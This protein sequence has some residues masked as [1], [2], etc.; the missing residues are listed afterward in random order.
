MSDICL[1]IDEDSMDK[2]LINGL[3]A[4]N[5][6][7]IT[8]IE[9]KTQSYTDEKQLSLATSLNRVLYSHNIS[10][11]CRLHT[12]FTTESKI[13]SGIA[14]LAQDYYIGEQLKAIMKFISVKTT[15]D[16][17]NQLEFLSKYLK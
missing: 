1:Y 11:F 15:D 4:R 9:T 10:D 14:L 12:E 5:V 17:Q 13:H 16:M 6:D 8:V 3:R 2:A 7:V